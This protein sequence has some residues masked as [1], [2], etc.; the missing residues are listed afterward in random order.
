MQAIVSATGNAAQLLYPSSAP[1]GSVAPGKLADLVVVTSNPLDDV[2]VFERPAEMVLI[3]KNGVAHKSTLP[4]RTI[5]D[6]RRRD[7]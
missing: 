4:S 6:N 5:F 3:T 1:V 2:S 7:A